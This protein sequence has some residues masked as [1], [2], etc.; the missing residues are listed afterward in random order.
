MFSILENGREC[1]LTEEVISC[2]ELKHSLH[3][4]G[5]TLFLIARGGVVLFSFGEIFL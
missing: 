1:V 2:I 5:G 4:G 3:V